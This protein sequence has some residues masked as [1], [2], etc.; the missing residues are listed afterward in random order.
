[1]AERKPTTR[2]KRVPQQTTFIQPA[3]QVKSGDILDVDEA[4]ALLRTS[5]RTVYNCV[6]A[7]TMPHARIGRKLLLSRA[8]LSPWVADGANL[9]K[10][11]PFKPVND[12]EQ[13]ILD[14]L[15]SL[16]NNGRPRVARHTCK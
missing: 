12:H 13:R 9:A 6:K 11:V 14:H 1:M 16:L 15:T 4:A 8:K 10:P 7:G 5:R 3:P 2:K